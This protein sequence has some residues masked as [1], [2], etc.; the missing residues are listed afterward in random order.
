LLWQA[1]GDGTIDLIGSD[2]S[3]CPPAMKRLEEGSFAT[4]WGG[5][6]SISLSLPVIW[7][8][9]SRR[10]FALSDLARWM[11]LKP[12]ELA[13]L[14]GTKGRIAP[15]LD[16]DFVVFQPEETFVVTNTKLHF[17][18]EVSPYVGER[19][20]GVVQQT[21][22]RGQCIFDQGRFISEPMG[23]EVRA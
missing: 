2:H 11:S 6:A 15:G 23:R 22:L 3:P 4:A 14:V 18:H 1:L 10:G 9:A 17:R 13:G 8:E 7:T 20:V 21:W 19:L 5:I 12:A 16:A